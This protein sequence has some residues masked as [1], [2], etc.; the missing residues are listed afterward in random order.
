MEVSEKIR[1]A[2]R[3]EEGEDFHE[4]LIEIFEVLRRVA[5]LAEKKAEQIREREIRKWQGFLEVAKE[6][7]IESLEKE[8]RE[9]LKWLKNASIVELVKEYAINVTIRV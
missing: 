4:K 5:E 8:A 7:N 3:V 6:Q 2:S 1:E 9:T